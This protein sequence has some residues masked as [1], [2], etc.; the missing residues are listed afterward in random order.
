MMKY[1]AHV[2][3]FSRFLVVPVFLYM[4]LGSILTQN[5]V[6]KILAAVIFYTYGGLS[7]YWDGFYARRYHFVSRFG[8]FMDPL[9]D[10]FFTLSTYA[11]Y[12][13][14]SIIYVPLWLVILIAVREI[15]IT[16][17]RI[18]NLKSSRPIHAERHGKI[19]TVLQYVSQG[20]VL[21]VLLG[22]A[23]IFEFTAY[24]TV[25]A[26]SS[27]ILFS[28]ES[29][30]NFTAVTGGLFSFITPFLFYSPFAVISISAA[31]TLWSGT[32]Y[33]RNA[34]RS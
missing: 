21:A 31:V 30:Q 27:H 7:D 3:T 10:K 13:C 18:Y 8:E 1:T 20:Y 17:I 34:I 9:A 25:T 5:Y 24:R 29:I 28:P 11:A 2:F 15:T 19:K 26:Q 23:C 14:I 22:Y 6:L 33:I 4:L 16:A 32:L 12:V